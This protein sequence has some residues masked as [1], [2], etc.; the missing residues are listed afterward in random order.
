MQKYTTLVKTICE[1]VTD[2]Q[3]GDSYKNI[4]KLAVPY[5]FDF[6][7]PFYDGSKK[8]EWERRFIQYFYMREIGFETVNL[9]KMELDNKLNIIM[10]YYNK[11]YIANE[12][13]FDPLVTEN[14]TTEEATNGTANTDISN[15]DITNTS[16]NNDTTSTHSTLPQSNISNFKDGKYMDDAAFTENSNTV[17]TDTAS[18]GTTRGTTTGDR[19]ETVKGY[20]GFVTSSLYSQYLEYLEKLKAIDLLIYDECEDLF[21]CLF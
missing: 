12:I 3:R 17:N 14:I 11:I 1:T 4:I 7:F 9:W 20:R 5:I 10:P 6:S 13:Q 19:K 15:N 16:S 8:E 21:M 2:A 18:T